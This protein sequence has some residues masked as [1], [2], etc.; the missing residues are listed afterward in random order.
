VFPPAGVA[1][2]VLVGVVL[3]VSGIPGLWAYGVPAVAAESA[4]VAL[5]AKSSSLQ[6]IDRVVYNNSCLQQHLDGCLR[7]RSTRLPAPLSF[8]RVA[9]SL[10]TTDSVPG[11]S[12]VEL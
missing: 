12:V 2:T 1:A 10:I 4:W 6:S 7:H 9:S 3:A 11:V 8:P 5:A